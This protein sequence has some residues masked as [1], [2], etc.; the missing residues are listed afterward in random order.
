MPTSQHVEPLRARRAF[1]DSY[2]GQVLCRIGCFPMILRNAYIT[3]RQ[4]VASSRGGSVVEPTIAGSTYDWQLF[5]HRARLMAAEGSS[6]VH[7]FLR[8]RQAMNVQEPYA[9]GGV[10]YRASSSWAAPPH[11]RRGDTAGPQAGLRRR[12]AAIGGAD[13]RA[14]SSWAA[15]PRRR[16]GDSAGPQAGLRRR[17][18]RSEEHTSELQSL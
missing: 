12:R 4:A 17:R 5:I 15:P 9:I 14:S 11:R 10:D 2:Q 13:C 1:D 3:T 7:I 16:R 6:P 18:A 8:T